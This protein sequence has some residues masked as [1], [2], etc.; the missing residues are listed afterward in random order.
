MTAIKA[1]QHCNRHDFLHSPRPAPSSSPARRTARPANHPAVDQWERQSRQPR[2]ATARWARQQRGA[3]ECYGDWQRAPRFSL[4]SGCCSKRSSP[5]NQN[6]AW[7]EGVDGKREKGGVG[8]WSETLS[9]VTL[10]PRQFACR[11][12]SAEGEAVRN[13]AVVIGGG[14]HGDAATASPSKL[15]RPLVRFRGGVTDSR[16]CWA[17]V[18]LCCVGG[19]LSYTTLNQKL[20][21]SIIS[22]R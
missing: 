10:V 12:A 13:P 5:A 16:G 9:T 8:S 11:E 14:L 22:C 15:V 18:M 4:A 17:L 1:I 6:A 2:N 19:P 3:G 7:W 21:W 20:S